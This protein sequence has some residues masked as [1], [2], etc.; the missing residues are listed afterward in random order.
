VSNIAAEFAL[1]ESH[2]AFVAE[3]DPGLLRRGVAPFSDRSEPLGLSRSGWGWESRLA[4]FDNDGVPEALQA[5][6]FVRG[7]ANRWPELQEL[8]M[9]NDE[10]LSDPANW[11]RF[12]PGD[13]LSGHLR[14]PFFVRRGARYVDISAELGLAEPGVSRGIATADVDGDGRLDMAVANQWAASTF[15]RNEAPGAGS[16][17]GLHLR[18]PLEPGPTRHRPGHPG[19]DTPGRAAI[20]AAAEV[21]RPD[22]RRLVAQADGGNGHSGKRSPDLHFGLGAV[23]PG[24]RVRV[25][26]RWRDPAGNVRGE[27][28]ALPPGWHTVVLGWAGTAVTTTTEN[29]SE[30]R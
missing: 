12:A 20:G 14:N 13:D 28:L 18:R 29:G 27:E 24:A 10:L 4:D 21:V 23:P 25:S 6:G 7:S 30:A 3:G 1:L 2:F 16:F 17:L 15:H 9:G 26:L 8:A 22:G 11:P 5:I 19:P